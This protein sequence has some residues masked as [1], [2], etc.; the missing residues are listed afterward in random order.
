MVR[1]RIV[2]KDE[3]VQ[4]VLKGLG[5][6]DIPLK[7]RGNRDKHSLNFELNQIRKW[8]KENSRAE[9]YAMRLVKIVTSDHAKIQER[10]D[11]FCKL[12]KPLQIL[13]IKLSSGRETQTNEKI[14]LN[15]ESNKELSKEMVLV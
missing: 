8:F 11:A 14:E 7:L 15:K 2:L 13:A 3:L 4:H 1:V 10:F 12:S 6:E 9:E 5:N